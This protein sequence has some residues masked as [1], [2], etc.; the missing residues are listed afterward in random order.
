MKTAAIAADLSP[1]AGTISAVPEASRD[2]RE[3]IKHFSLNDAEPWHRGHLTRLYGVW[4]NLN[5]RY[6]GGVMVP[7]IL[8]L[9]EPVAP[10]VYGDCSTVSGNGA[11]SQIR[12]RPSLLTGTHPHVQRGERY[13]EGRYRFVADVLMHEQIHQFH[14][15]IAHR[16]EGNYHGHG[17]LF[18]AKCN[19]LGA[20]L[21]LPEV[22]VRTRP[23]HRGLPRCAQWPHSVRS[24]SHYDGAYVPPNGDSREA[25]EIARCVA[26]LRR[27]APDLLAGAD[28]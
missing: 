28:G 11:Q 6:Y 2:L 3:H 24:L 14:Q 22:I 18:C 10:D 25:K 21:G 26:Y 16:D 17:P 7:P 19:E 12:L 13:A 1:L 23:G 20:D 8:Q 5:D 4:E 27:H 15:E 9:L